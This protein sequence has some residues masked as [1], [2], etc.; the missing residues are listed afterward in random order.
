MGFVANGA[1][2]PSNI[3]ISSGTFFPDISLDEIRSV[4]RIDGSVTD[5]RLRQVIRE[6]IIDVNRLLASLVMKAEKLAD[7][8]VNQIDGKSDT[9]VLYLSAVSNGV[10]AKVNE[11]YRNYDSTN[12][13]V[14]KTEVTEC[15][16]EDY[17]R[18]KQ[19]AI[20]QLKGENHSVVELI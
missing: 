1:V 16:V 13:G 11:N 8:A 9:E 5:V 10:A 3:I 20:Q 2:T 7:L 18:N 15:S 19:W 14:K 17:R 4:V 12:S 6:E